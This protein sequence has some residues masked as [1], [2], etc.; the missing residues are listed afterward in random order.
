MSNRQ[1]YVPTAT[2]LRTKVGVWGGGWCV[3]YQWA[4]CELDAI[5]AMQPLLGGGAQRPCVSPNS[6]AVNPGLH[7]LMN[8]RSAADNAANTSL[9]YDWMED[10]L[11][12]ELALRTAAVPDACAPMRRRPTT[13]THLLVT[14]LAV[15]NLPP[16]KKHITMAKVHA[17]NNSTLDVWRARAPP[18]TAIVDARAP[19]LLAGVPWA[20]AQD[21][22]HWTMGARLVDV[23]VSVGLWCGSTPIT[24]GGVCPLWPLLQS[25]AA[26]PGKSSRFAWGVPSN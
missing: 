9:L 24:T 14:P 3:S 2:W 4:V 16:H 20:H 1:G 8:K 21:G 13:F 19:E 11:A 25:A 26:C 5:A 6:I 12:S 22:M 18:P 23:A 10:V 17:I 7:P 15:H